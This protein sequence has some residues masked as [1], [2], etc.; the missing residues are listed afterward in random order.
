MTRETQLNGEIAVAVA[1]CT[2]PTRKLPSRED[3]EQ[4]EDAPEERDTMFVYRW[5]CNL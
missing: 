4:R 3:A 1:S 2:P 5:R